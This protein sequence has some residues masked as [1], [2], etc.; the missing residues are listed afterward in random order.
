MFVSVNDG[1]LW[2]SK[3][4]FFQAEL[5]RNKDVVNGYKVIELLLK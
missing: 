4:P 5:T 1:L 3:L 2:L